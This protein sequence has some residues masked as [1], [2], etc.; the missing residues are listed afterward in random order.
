MVRSMLDDK[1]QK[2]T[3]HSY[4]VD[5]LMVGWHVKSR[6]NVLTNNEWGCSHTKV[7]YVYPTC[8]YE[9]WGKLNTN[10]YIVASTKLGFLIIVIRNIK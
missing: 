10:V 1:R 7:L 2:C 6:M 8:V 9:S 4:C 3:F 5:N